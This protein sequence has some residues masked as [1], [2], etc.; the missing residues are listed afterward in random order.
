MAFLSKILSATPL[1]FVLVNAQDGTVGGQL[2]NGLSW[3]ATVMNA[4]TVKKQILEH[5]PTLELSKSS[6]LKMA[7]YDVKTISFV[8]KLLS[9]SESVSFAGSVDAS[10][11]CKGTFVL[12]GSLSFSDTV[13]VDST[14]KLSIGGASSAKTSLTEPSVTGVTA[15]PT[16]C[17]DAVKTAADSISKNFDTEAQAAVIDIVQTL[18]QGVPPVLAVPPGIDVQGQTTQGCFL[19]SALFPE[20]SITSNQVMSAGTCPPTPVDSSLKGKDALAW[21]TG[22]SIDKAV[23]TA[24]KEGKLKV[25]NQLITLPPAAATVLP[26]PCQLPNGTSCP[27]YLDLN[28]SIP[29]T[30]QFSADKFTLTVPKNGV[31]VAFHAQANATAKPQPVLA[32]FTIG[33]EISGT[34][35]TIT[36]VAGGRISVKMENVQLSSFAVESADADTVSSIELAWQIYINPQLTTTLQQ[37]YEI[38]VDLGLNLEDPVIVF[39]ANNTI[40]VASSVKAL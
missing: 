29:P 15:S 39:G 20:Q 27:I 7:S 6:S 35:V 8:N 40:S 18:L 13:A 3:G 5:L 17:L 34:N 30:V 12:A 21:T 22:D 9:I 14:G 4:D 11:D 36:P 2:N 23:A 19:L 16:T 28:I 1:C 26:N 31:S 10:S 24:Q 25:E 38:P 37:G 32:P 33:V